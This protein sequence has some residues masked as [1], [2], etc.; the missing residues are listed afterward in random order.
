M[1]FS[2]NALMYTLITVA[3]NVVYLA[4]F[5][6]VLNKMFNSEKIMFAK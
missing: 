3:A 2:P 1:T 6:A 5:V 4:I